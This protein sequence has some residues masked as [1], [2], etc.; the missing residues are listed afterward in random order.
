[1]EF[2]PGTILAEKIG[3]NI[4]LKDMLIVIG[5]KERKLYGTAL[6]DTSRKEATN[7][8]CYYVSDG[9][10]GAVAPYILRKYYQPLDPYHGFL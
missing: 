5:Q 6:F 7:Y 4:C 3:G 1:M 8:I 2:K 10:L 9:S